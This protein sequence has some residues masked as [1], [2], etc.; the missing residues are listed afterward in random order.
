MRGGT[1]DTAGGEGRGRR[2]RK[3]SRSPQREITRSLQSG[4]LVSVGWRSTGRCWGGWGGVV[5]VSRSPQDGS[6]HVVAEERHAGN[7]TREVSASSKWGDIQ[8]AEGWK[9]PVCRLG[10]GGGSV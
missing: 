7:H 10:R 8:V 3:I 2:R 1:K 9:S 4:G 5:R 6:L